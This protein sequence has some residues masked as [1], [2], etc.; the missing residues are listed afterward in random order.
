MSSLRTKSFYVALVAATAASAVLSAVI[1]ER[2][3]ALHDLKKRETE[4]LGRLQAVQEQNRRTRAER[5]ALLTSPR[6]IERVAREDYGYVAPG[7][8]AEEYQPPRP[9][10]ETAPAPLPPATRWD[11]I[12][13]RGEYPWRIPVLV[14]AGFLVIFPLIDLLRLREPEDEPAAR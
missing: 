13:G 14:F 1:A 12:L 6:Y 10:S 5:Q 9:G 4:L 3:A 2:R 7:E 8:V 11:W